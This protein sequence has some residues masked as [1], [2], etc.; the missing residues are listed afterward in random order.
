[1]H[2]GTER[3]DRFDR[4]V[5][6]LIIV[7]L[8]AALAIVTRPLHSLFNDPLTEDGFYVLS[9]ARQ[10]GLGR[11][12][13]YDGE[14]LSNGFQP[15]WVFL[16]APLFW[17]S[18]GDRAIGIRYVLGFHWLLHA[19]NASL[20]AALA[21]RLFGK[22]TDRPRS[23]GLIAA[24]AFLSSAFIWW[25]DFNGLETALS[26]ACLLAFILCYVSIDH[27]NKLHLVGCGALLGLVVLA[28]ID[29][30]FF[31]IL[32]AIVQL[33]RSGSGWKERVFDAAC[34]AA[35]AFL[36][37]SPWWAFNVIAFGHLTPSSGLALQD[38]APTRSRYMTGVGALVRAAT[39]PLLDFLDANTWPRAVA[40]LPVLGLAIYWTWPELRA[41][42]R[43]LDRSIAEVLLALCLFIAILAL[44]YPSSS[45]ATF[46]YTRYLAPASI[47]GVLFWTFVILKIIQ[48]VN[49]TLVAAGL[50][51]LAV[52]IPVLAVLYYSN[53]GKG[54][55]LA[56][57]VA[58]VETHVPANDLVGAVQ[59]GTLGFLRDRVV[60]LDGRVDFSALARR[61]D[62]AQ[63]VREKRI[64]WVADWPW[65]VEDYLGPDAAKQ[66]W[67][68]VATKG[69]MT[70][71][72]YEGPPANPAR[73]EGR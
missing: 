36:V 37:S 52:Q 12:V 14:T 6:V 20:T 30:V 72:R 46:F 70:L 19:V 16:C 56:D 31:V 59:A 41:F 53:H 43:T 54:T 2:L 29:A 21:A 67:L 62:M 64:R 45:W 9:V 5:V 22:F 49:R 4:L 38:W 68:P 26:T 50:A 35:P 18:D 63:Y 24:L 48:R 55:I 66:G 65:L 57:Q 10:I 42:F 7:A 13:T 11:G 61:H 51:V 28:R 3:L 25:N 15:L 33:L 40:R 44:W 71:Y 60:N 23:A 39:T 1:M 32:L 69:S 73:S 34:L 27:R 17:F 58:L 8:G 47:L